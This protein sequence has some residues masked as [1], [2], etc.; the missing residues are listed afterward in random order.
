[1]Y[2]VAEKYTLEEIQELEALYPGPYLVY[3]VEEINKVGCTRQSIEERHLQMQRRSSEILSL[4]EVLFE[5][6]DLLMAAEKER[7]NKALYGIQWNTTDYIND[8]KRQVVACS[9]KVR[10]KAFENRDFA[11]EWTKEKR[12]AMSKAQ[13]PVKVKVIASEVLEVKYEYLGYKKGNKKEIT[14]TKYFR[15]FNSQC[16]ASNYFRKKGLNISPQDISLILNPNYRHMERHGYT[17][18]NA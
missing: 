2:S 17:F 11:K 4:P 12:K 15:T 3:R 1:M 16:D 5:T 18:K 8:L 10:K 6:Y 9:K 14:K 13:D 7:E